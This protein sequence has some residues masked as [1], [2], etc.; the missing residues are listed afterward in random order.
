MGTSAVGS[1]EDIKVFQLPFTS[2]SPSSTPSTDPSSSPSFI[3]S[4][5]ASDTPSF[6][7]STDPSSSPSSIPS[8]DPSKSPSS[9]VTTGPSTSA[10]S[11]QDIGSSAPTQNL[12]SINMD[13]SSLSGQTSETIGGPLEGPLD[14]TDTLT[15]KDEDAD[16][17]G[18]AAAGRAF[19]ITT[20]RMESEFDGENLQ[21]EVHL[22][23]DYYAPSDVLNTTYDLRLYD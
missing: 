8:T 10:S 1:A 16:L 2:A 17:Y 7:P 22:V 6:T 11:I 20:V 21:N 3:P 9:I 5:S 14:T 19:N 4:T 23:Y 15:A 18:E 12:I 13:S